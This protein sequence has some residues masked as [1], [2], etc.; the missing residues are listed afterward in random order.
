[1]NKK[2]EGKRREI[3]I[4]EKVG[5][6]RNRGVR[7]RNHAPVGNLAPAKPTRR[8]EKWTCDLPWQEN[9]CCRPCTHRHTAHNTYMSNYSGI[10]FCISDQRK[11]ERNKDDRK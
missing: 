6:E 11:K 2:K 7:G 3:I 4:R 5:K 10:W 8:R 1:M 9:A